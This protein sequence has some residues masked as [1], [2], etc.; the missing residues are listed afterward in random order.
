MT[1]QNHYDAIIIG[2]RAAGASLAILLGQRGKNVLL[3][4]K[5][6]FPSD[7]LSTHHLSHIHYLDKLGVLDEVEALGLRKITRMRTHI[8]DSLIEG[9]RSHYTLIPRRKDLDQ[10]LIAKALTYN[11]VTLMEN[12]PIKGLI[13]EGDH[14]I[15][16]EGV[17]ADK[18]MEA[19]GELVVGADGKRSRTAEWA[20]AETYRNEGAERPVFYG[21]Y[22]N[23]KALEEPTTEIFLQGGRIG[24]LFPMEPGMD[25]LGLEIHPDEYQAF[26]QNPRSQFETAYRQLYR[27]ETRLQDARLE[28]KVFGTA[29]VP[30][31]FRT[32]YGKGWALIGDA[33]HCKD[34]STGL[35][36]NDA[37]LQS[38]LLAEAWDRHDEGAAWESVMEDFQN[39]RDQQ[40]LPAFE[41][42]LDYV[43]SLRAWSQDEAALFNAMAANPIVWNRLV[44]HLPDL[45]QAK[46]TDLPQLMGSVIEEAKAFGYRP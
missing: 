11:S 29:G 32:A 8:A 27:M 18:Q 39:K 40:M 44:S 13:K 37:F 15:G 30:N 35:G 26:A 20:G 33:G 19:Y 41:L 28:G 21:Y 4:D 25:C 5:A 3:V 46:S 6:A 16:V 36:I 22:R 43:Q 42:T 24:F 45:L 14:V 7:T 12:T 23:V 34:P 17:Y 38:F 2:A 9:P 10:I 1:E 31:F